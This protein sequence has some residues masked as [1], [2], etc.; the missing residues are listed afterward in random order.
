MGAL[1][2]IW[3]VIRGTFLKDVTWTWDD[4]YKFTRF[5]KKKKKKKENGIPGHK[6]VHRAERMSRYS[7]I[8]PE[9]RIPNTASILHW[10]SINF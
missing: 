2:S 4:E 1:N 10:F 3:T 6:S 5:L 8:D 9:P 7:S